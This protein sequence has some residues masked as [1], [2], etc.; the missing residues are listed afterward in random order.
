MTEEKKHE[1]CG[2]HDH[3]HEEGC[4]GGHDHSE[5]CGCGHEHQEMPTMVLS[6]E[7]G[8]ELTCFVLTEFEI[9]EKSYIALL[10][11]DEE[12][13]YLY[14]MEESEDGEPILINIEDD[15]EFE[16]ASNVLNTILEEEF[17]E[18]LDEE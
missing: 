17:D 5:E 7:D 13:V 2:G 18:D 6:L 1:C 8:E 10:P 12:S 11:Q 14:Q 15:E 4:C 3:S 16:T 9:K